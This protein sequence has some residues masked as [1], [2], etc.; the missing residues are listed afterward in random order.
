[1]N[2]AESVQTLHDRCAIYTSTATAEKLLDLVGWTV[3]NDL[4]SAVLL[5]PCAGEGAILV[6]AA[7]RLTASLRRHQIEISR[8]SLSERI[9]SFEFHPSTATATRSR[10]ETLLLSEGVT[11]A[12][13]QW[14]AR[15]WLRQRDFL[16]ADVS[17]ATHVVANPPYVRW[18]KLPPSLAATYRAALRPEATRGDLA[19]AFIDRMLDWTKDDGE[20]VALVSDRW[21]FA[22]YGEGFLAQTSDR[23]WTLN[24]HE[25]RPCNPFVRDVG[26]Y[27]A[28][29]GFRKTDKLEAAPTHFTRPRERELHGALVSLHG[30]IVDAG[31][32]IRVGPALGC[33]HTYIVKSGA[34][35]SVEAELLR[36]YVGRAELVDGTTKSSGAYVVSPYDSAGKLVDLRD[37]PGFAKWAKRRRSILSARSCV[38]PGGPW[39]RTIDAIGLQWAQSPKLLVPE[40]CQAPQATLDSTGAIPAHSIY[41]IWSTEWPVETLQRVL[42]AGLLKVTAEA[43]APQLKHGWFR[44]YRR[45]LCQT[46]LPKWSLL[47]ADHQA[48]FSGSDPKVFRAAF[49]ELFGFEADLP[50]GSLAG[51]SH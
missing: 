46:P 23:G 34:S 32:K 45:F 19:V 15:T 7:R 44:F 16:T 29:V 1:M 20:V 36:P 14:L 6:E 10:I 48:A 3:E 40:L 31:C 12:T 11:K 28:I 13:A 37:W 27:S 47:S 42:N 18:A 41:A 26:V 51:Q 33:G 49:L 39:W 30:T 4:S 9:I 5:E 43:L 38:R 8:D 21:M 35:R 17:T 24:V 2:A 25:E 50:V 22:Q